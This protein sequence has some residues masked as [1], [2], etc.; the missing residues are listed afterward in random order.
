MGQNV[1]SV[2]EFRLA[3]ASVNGPCKGNNHFI[4]A[5]SYENIKYDILSLCPSGG[6]IGKIRYFFAKK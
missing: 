5:H 2:E 3:F 4:I 1:G 6:G